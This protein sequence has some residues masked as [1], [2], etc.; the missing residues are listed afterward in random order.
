MR[1]IICCYL[2]RTSKHHL[3]DLPSLP[4]CDSRLWLPSA[5]GNLDGLP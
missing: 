5:M 1:H 4:V 2:C 3:L